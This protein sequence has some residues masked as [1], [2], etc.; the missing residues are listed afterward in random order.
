MAGVD[1]LNQFPNSKMARAV[2]VGQSRFQSSDEPSISEG[3]ELNVDI[4]GGVPLVVPAAA[5]YAVITAVGGPLYYTTDGST[6]SATNFAGMIAQG[7]AV[8]F[9]GQSF[10]KSLQLFGTSASVVYMQ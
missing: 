3:S 5:T 1:L 4:S 6:P 8:S 2:K 7:G 10:L 9:Y